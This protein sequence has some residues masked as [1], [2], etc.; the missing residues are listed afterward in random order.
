M[1]S[2]VYLK[3]ENGNI[4]KGKPITVMNGPFNQEGTK[5]CEQL[6]GS[7]TFS[8]PKPVSL[9]SRFLSFTIN[10]K[11]SKNDIILDFFSGSSTT[12]HAVM[13]LNAEDK[14]NRR[15]IQVQLP[16]P[17]GEKTA[18]FKAGYSNLSLIHI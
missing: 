17:C 3:D 6:L 7:K 1:R 11:S 12:A 8:F 13:K 5:E 18:A 9:I 4:R 16:E 2:K 14:G 15:Y 10:S